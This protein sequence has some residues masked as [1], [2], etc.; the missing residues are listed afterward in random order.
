MKKRTMK[1]WIPKNTCYCYDSK[2]I[3]KWLSIN[4]NKEY[5]LNGYCK[6]LKLGDWEE[7]GTELI[8]DQC[9]ECGVSSEPNYIKSAKKYGKNKLKEERK[10]KFNV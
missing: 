7:N 4:K 9:K 1:K 6:Y 10:N 3:C 5:Q 2:K 8:W